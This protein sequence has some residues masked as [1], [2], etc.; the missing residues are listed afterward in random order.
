MDMPKVAAAR[1]SVPVHPFLATPD[2]RRIFRESL[3]NQY[4]TQIA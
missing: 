2:S 4:D 3:W 1:A